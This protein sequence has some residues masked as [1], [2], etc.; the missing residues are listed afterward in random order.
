MFSNLKS[1]EHLQAILK[2]LQMDNPIKEDRF[3]LKK[4]K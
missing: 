4:K 2:V 3:S 1:S